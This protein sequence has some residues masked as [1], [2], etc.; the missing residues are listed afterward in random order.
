VALSL[1]DL[2]L[3]SRALRGAKM[4]KAQAG[5]KK[6]DAPE[7]HSCGIC[8]YFDKPDACRLVAGDIRPEYGCR[9]FEKG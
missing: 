1:A 3:K 2:R 8:E 9:F 5:Y 4:T 7:V 6:S